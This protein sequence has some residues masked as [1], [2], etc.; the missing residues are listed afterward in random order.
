MMRLPVNEARVCKRF[1]EAVLQSRRGRRH[2]MRSAAGTS[3]SMKKINRRTLGTC[4]IPT[5]TL[6]DQE[7]L[8][9]KLQDL[10]EAAN[11]ANACHGFANAMKL[12]LI[13]SFH[14]VLN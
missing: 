2:M 1:L 8:L 13:E 5:P 12:A 4:L 7:R 11:S 9:C 6:S 3:G 14:G 10:R